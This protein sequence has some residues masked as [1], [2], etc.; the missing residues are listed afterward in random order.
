M[1]SAGDSAIAGRK[2]VAGQREG[3]PDADAEVEMQLSSEG[4]ADEGRVRD[5]ACDAAPLRAHLRDREVRKQVI[6][7]FM[8]RAD[9]K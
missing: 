2:E 4:E 5:S 8:W 1:P 6:E 3:I 7:P 9:G